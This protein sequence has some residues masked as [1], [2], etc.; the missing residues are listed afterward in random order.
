RWTRDVQPARVHPL[1]G[2][3]PEGQLGREAAD[4]EGPIQ[5]RATPNPRVV[6]RAPARFAEVATG[7]AGQEAD[8]AL[9]LL[10]HHRELPGDRALSQR[11]QEGVAG[12][13][14]APGPAA[15]TPADTVGA[16]VTI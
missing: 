4:G 9:C 3:V 10:R 5:P 15:S 12:G 8:G 14:R 13:G 11:G 6:S 2:N 16:C 7:R 1:L